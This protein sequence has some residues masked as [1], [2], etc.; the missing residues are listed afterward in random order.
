MSPSEEEHEDD[1]ILIPFCSTS[2]FG[3]IIVPYHIL[4][5][6]Q[7]RSYHNSGTCDASFHSGGDDDDDSSQPVQASSIT[8]SLLYSPQS[9]VTASGSHG[10]I[11]NTIKHSTTAASTSNK[12]PSPDI[13]YSGRNSPFFRPSTPQPITLTQTLSTPNGT[14]IIKKK[15]KQLL[16]RSKGRR[17]HTDVPER[18]SSI[19]GAVSN[20]VTCIVG[21][22][23]IGRKNC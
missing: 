6:S 21:A 18:K 20:L 11:I 22:G 1:N 3:E 2:T 10:R 4:P 14:R 12:S 7:T 19:L 5:Q 15:Q 8:T 16:L 9:N 17:R 23:I 13:N